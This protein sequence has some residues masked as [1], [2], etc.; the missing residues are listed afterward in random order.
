[1][2]R[3]LTSFIGTAA[4]ALLALGLSACNESLVPVLPE[5]NV[6]QYVP[7]AS[8]KYTMG[9]VLEQN[10]S[11][12]VQL[13]LD[14][15]FRATVRGGVFLDTIPVNLTQEQRDK[16]FAVEEGH[17]VFQLENSLPVGANIG[18]RFVNA[19]YIT[20]YIPSSMSGEE[21]R[22]APAVV[23]PDG[24]VLEPQIFSTEIL[25]T[26]AD[27]QQII[28]SSWLLVRV[29]ISTPD[30]APISF[31]LEDMLKVRAFARVEVRT[32]ISG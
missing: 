19:D 12:E 25:V 2:T 15:I 13:G 10:P 4:A 16:L 21:F 27:I 22:V 17:I 26:Q 23:A 28:E 7:F 24:T 32:G 30:G 3:I 11:I 20:L 6:D 18:L 1:M 29:E 8:E 5:W 31:R 14:G 9:D